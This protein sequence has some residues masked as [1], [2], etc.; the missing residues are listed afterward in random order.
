MN[1]FASETPTLYR[2]PGYQ[3][4]L[5]RLQPVRGPGCGRLVFL[6]SVGCVVLFMVCGGIYAFIRAQT[7]PKQSPAVLTIVATRPPASQPQAQPPT[8]DAWSAQGTALALATASP[9]LDYCWWQ[10]P[11]ALPSPTPLP[12]TPDAWALQGTAIALETG[13][14]TGTP[15]PT[16]APPRAWCDLVTPGLPAT[17]TFTPFPLHAE[18]TQEVVPPTV[19]PVPASRTPA[20]TATTTLYPE[21][22]IPQSQPAAAPAQPAAPQQVLVVQTQ[23]VLQTAAPAPTQPPRVVI[24]T[25]TPLPTSTPTET[26][27]ASE[28]PTETATATATET[29]TETP[30]ET[31][32]PTATETPTEEPTP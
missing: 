10:T 16:A 12:V 30:T 8:L 1:P 27:T 14:P 22:Q 21:I 19:T 26:A 18:T 15:L 2:P 17:A 6:M 7:S 20:P 24:V 3:V 25:A 31:A 32:T 13:T 11:T 4:D 9:T 28:T 29:P 23:I 5:D